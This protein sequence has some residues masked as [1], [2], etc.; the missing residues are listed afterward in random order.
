MQVHTVSQLYIYPIKSLGG[1][2]VQ[3]SMAL[4]RGFQYDRRWMLVDGEGKF[5]TQRENA[6]LARFAC[7]LDEGQLV[8][9]H[10][11]EDL[12]IDLEENKAEAIEVE[13]WSDRLQAYGVRKEISEWFSDHLKTPA[14]LVRMTE[15]SL[16]SKQLKVAPHKIELSFADGYPYLIL[17][18]ASM[19]ALNSRLDQ[20]LPMDR[21]RANIIVTT[22]EAHEED[23]W[24]DA[25]QL[26]R[27][28]LKVIKPCA[29]C[30]VT[31][32]DQETGVK[33]IEPLKSLATYRQWDNK[34]WFGAN[35]ICAQEGI[36]K[37]GDRA[38]I[39]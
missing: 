19:Q 23:T 5:L 32:I 12:R 9:T 37:V 20:A 24:Q 36:V 21:F 1:I 16:R 33:G 39:T 30:Q 38:V 3:E 14:R 35:A 22:T 11:A 25:F 18:D 8:I 7:Q 13:V 6:E 17:G 10:D 29:R 28:Q 34:I 2:A 4:P 27:A 31:T 15:A 26:G